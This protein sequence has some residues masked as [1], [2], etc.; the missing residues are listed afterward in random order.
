MSVAPSADE[1][2]RGT[3]RIT[4]SANGHRELVCISHGSST[5]YWRAGEIVSFRN[6]LWRV[7]ERWEDD[8]GSVTLTLA[9]PD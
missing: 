5:V 8:S 6:R 2:G 4:L 1:D 7:V 9:H 3:T